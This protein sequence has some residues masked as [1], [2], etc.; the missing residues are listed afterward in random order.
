[1]QTKKVRNKICFVGDG[2]VGKTSLIRRYVH[3]V[4]DDKY[5]A[6]IGTKM[7]RKE[8]ILDYPEKDVRFRI[9]AIIWDIMGQKAFKRLL[10]EA[11]FRGAKGILGVCSLTDSNS[12]KGLNDWVESI[13]EVVGEVPI[14]IL[15]NKSDLETEIRLEND[16]I[17]DIATSWGAQHLYT[18]AKTGDNVDKAFLAIGKEMIKKQFNIT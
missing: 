12:L 6:T 5:L 3:D 11:Y 15:A 14:V 8:I 16:E 18:S 7:T 10:H 4:F 17:E 13:K 9:D 2:G 1:M